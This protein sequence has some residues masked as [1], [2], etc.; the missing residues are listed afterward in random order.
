[1][2]VTIRGVVHEIQFRYSV[3]GTVTQAFIVKPHATE[4]TPEG[5]PVL[6]SVTSGTA[7][8]SK[9]DRVQ[10]RIGRKIALAKA[11]KFCPYLLSKE[12]RAEVWNSLFNAGFR[13]A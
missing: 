2:K 4:L 10:K 3:G 12:E 1:M 7:F 8:T 13:R 6:V 11:L 9:K 5:R